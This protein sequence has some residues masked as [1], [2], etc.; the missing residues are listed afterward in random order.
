MH[1]HILGHV[2]GSLPLRELQIKEAPVVPASEASLIRVHLPERSL[3]EAH[4]W[5]FTGGA[6]RQT[7]CSATDGVTA[8]E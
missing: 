8:A 6:P 1:I 7:T 3:G 5:Q 4:G 2:K